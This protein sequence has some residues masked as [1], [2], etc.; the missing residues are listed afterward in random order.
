VV[1]VGVFIALFC[2][3][4]PAIRHFGMIGAA[5][6]TVGWQV[7]ERILIAVCAVRVVDARASDI[8]LYDDLFKVTGVTIVAGVLAYVV[9]NLIP[10]VHLIPRIL[11]VGVCVCAVYLPAMYLLRL[12]GWD[13][14]TKERITAF[15]RKTLGQ[16]RNANA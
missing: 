11:A 3:L 14:L 6:S 2:T 8:R 4:G 10:P 12:P 15:V 1:R 13:M 16:L 5:V 9:R 7:I